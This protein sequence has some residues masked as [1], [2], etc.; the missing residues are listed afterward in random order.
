MSSVNDELCVV[1]PE[2]R[3]PQIDG[4]VSPEKSSTNLS[5]SEEIIEWNFVS[6]G[7][8]PLKRIETGIYPHAGETSGED[9][10]KS[11][12]LPFAFP[13]SKLNAMAPAFVPNKPE[14]VPPRFR[15]P[16]AQIGDDRTPEVQAA[17]AGEVDVDSETQEFGSEAVVNPHFRSPPGPMGQGSPPGP[18]PAHHL[19]AHLNSRRSKQGV[20]H[21]LA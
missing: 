10:Q 11:C 2:F 17:V 6:K 4:H 13:E 8:D 7:I 9:E 12:P 14:K 5:P 3:I 21:Q 18:P 20:L 19:D 1:A 16:P 15:S